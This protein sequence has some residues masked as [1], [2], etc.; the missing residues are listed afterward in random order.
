MEGN[1]VLINGMTGFLSPDG[2]DLIDNSGERWI[3]MK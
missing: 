2:S 1:K 3:G